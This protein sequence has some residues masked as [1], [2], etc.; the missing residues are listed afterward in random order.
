ML[1]MI[2][3]CRQSGDTN[4]FARNLSLIAGRDVMFSLAAGVQMQLDSAVMSICQSYKR[5]VP[6]S[7]CHPQEGSEVTSTIFIK[8]NVYTSLATSSIQA[9]NNVTFILLALLL[10]L[11]WCVIG[12]LKQKRRKRRP[13]DYNVKRGSRSFHNRLQ[14]V[15]A[16][17]PAAPFIAFRNLDR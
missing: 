14:M 5:Y 17:G 7:E 15:T 6:G 4:Q 12:Y 1:L 8:N 13:S 11:F 2:I 16:A 3:I 9:L 10:Q